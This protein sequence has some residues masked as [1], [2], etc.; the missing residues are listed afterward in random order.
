[1]KKNLKIILILLLPFSLLFSQNTDTTD[2]HEEYTPTAVRSN[3]NNKKQN[4]ND[5]AK[6]IIRFKPVHT[7]A[8]AIFGYFQFMASYVRYVHPKIGIPVQIEYAYVGYSSIAVFSGIEAVPVTHREK[9]GLYL[10]LLA[11]PVVVFDAGVGLGAYSHIGYQ[12][13]TKKGFVLTTA[14][15]VQTGFANNGTEIT[16]IIAPSFMLDIGFGW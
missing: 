5:Y 7:I 4:Y 1:M 8:G 10:N 6:N 16:G 9:S 13:F 14:I 11:G 3:Y 15:G 12:L 2:A